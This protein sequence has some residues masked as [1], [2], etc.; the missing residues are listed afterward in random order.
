MAGR[1][2]G[3]Q[4][5]VRGHRPLQQ[6]YVVTAEYDPLRD[7]GEYYAAKLRAAGTEVVTFTVGDGMN[8][9]FF[10]WAVRVDKAG[11]AMAESCQWLR[12]IFQ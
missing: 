8:H 10:F 9:G 3:S 4:G 2:M 11:E 1:P 12:R 5:L 7:E 6:S